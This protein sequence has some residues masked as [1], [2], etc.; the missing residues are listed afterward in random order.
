VAWDLACSTQRIGLAGGA[1]EA[2]EQPAALHA[3][4]LLEPLKDDRDDEPIRNELAILH[5]LLGL[6]ADGGARFDGG[7]EHVAC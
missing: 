5:L 1:R 6:H 2:I 4:R 3:V 7:T